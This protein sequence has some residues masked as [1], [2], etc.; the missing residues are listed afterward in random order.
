MDPKF[1]GKLLDRIAELAK[2][3]EDR[4]IEYL[5]KSGKASLA[6]RQSKWIESQRAEGRRMVKAWLAGDDI[7][8]LKLR[9]PGPRG[10]IDW[11]AVV[12]AALSAPVRG[13]Q[14]ECIGR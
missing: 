5:T 9:F 14:G 1:E 4:T 12:E 2:G 10:G 8:A 11:P 6:E 13:A 3:N 7:A